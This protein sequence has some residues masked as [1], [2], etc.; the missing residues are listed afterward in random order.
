MRENV[1]IWLPVFKPRGRRGRGVSGAWS[2][3]WVWEVVLLDE[4]GVFLA[5]TA[6]GEFCSLP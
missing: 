2:R 1:R 6:R 5:V 3:M 4:A